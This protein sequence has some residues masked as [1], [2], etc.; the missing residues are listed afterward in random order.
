MMPAF[1]GGFGGGIGQLVA[2]GRGQG[3]M[4]PFGP[5]GMASRVGASL[6]GQLL[7]RR[8]KKPYQPQQGESPLAGGTMSG[9]TG[10]APRY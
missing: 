6:A 3:G 4:N 2:G 1:S 9:T 7:K 5:W 8:P 10:S